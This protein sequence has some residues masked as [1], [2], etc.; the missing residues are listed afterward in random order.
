MK[1][2]DFLNGNKMN[3]S[4]VRAYL[5]RLNRA[6]DAMACVKGSPEYSCINGTVKFYQIKSGVLILSEVF[7]LPTSNE[8]CSD[9]IFAFHIHSGSCCSG[10]EDDPF[11]DA[12]T[13]YNPEH[14]EHPY[15][16]GDL[17][18]LFGNDG[19]AFS[20]FLTDR[21]TV[22]EII[23]KTVIIH[24]NPDDFKTQPSGNAGEKIA[25]GEIKSFNKR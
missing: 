5:S 21:F 22:S 14:C 7:G 3:T 18:P 10:N 9:K 15:H 20:L 16:A 25:C 8:V 24:S 6:P 13:H 2:S 4:M 1:R 23:G 19:Y 12:G 11:A 17:P